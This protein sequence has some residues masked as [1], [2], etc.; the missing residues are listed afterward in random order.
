MK[1]GDRVEL[2][3]TTDEYTTL[4]SGDRGTVRNIDDLGTVHIN[5]DVGS[6]LGMIPGED[7]IRKIIIREEKLKRILK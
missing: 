2:V 3:S 6:S 5:W 1:K 7:V 4:K